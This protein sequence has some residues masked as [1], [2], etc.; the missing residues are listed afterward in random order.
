MYI[1]SFNLEPPVFAGKKFKD[2]NVYDSKEISF[3]PFVPTL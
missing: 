3:H 2:E 1:F